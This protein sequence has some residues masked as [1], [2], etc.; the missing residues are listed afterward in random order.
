MANKFDARQTISRDT[1]SQI[2]PYLSG[3][4]L[5]NILRSID[6]DLTSPLRM[7]ASNPVDRVVSIGPSLVS[8]S[9]SDRQK[10]I[11][12]VNNLLPNFTS[13][14]I[15]FPASSGGTITVSPGTNNI[16]TVA[17]G[18]YIKATIFMEGSGDL[19]VVMG[20]E[21]AVEANASVAIV[22]EGTLAIGY[23]V[24]HNTGGTIDNISQNNIVQFVLG[25]GSGTASPQG[26]SDEAALGLGDDE[27]TFVF[28]SPLDDTDYVPQVQI[29]NT[30]DADPEVIGL[31]V[32]DKTVNG[33]TV[34]L[35][36]PTDSANYLVSYIIPSLQNQ[37]GS[38]NLGN[39]V[40]NVTVTLPI[41]LDNTMYAVTCA[42][43]NLTDTDPS[44]INAII[45]DKTTTTFDVALSVPTDSANYKLE[46][47][48]A[49][50]S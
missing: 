5:D 39:A 25:G 22:P 28:P 15:T 18:N 20:T 31:I 35:S 43:S 36:V 40:D 33:F 47:H 9:E 26:L 38:E 16:L 1:L 13:G 45:T 3:Q 10:S 6:S 27:I 34:K 44:F 49:Y 50:F 19:G 8:N 12:H 48:V 42:I 29:V 17:S 24:L 46:F 41:S 32:T 14:T 23:V 30:T 4:E 37:T 7:D 2:L 11:S 21:N